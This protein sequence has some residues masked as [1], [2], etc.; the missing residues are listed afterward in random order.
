MRVLLQLIAQFSVTLFLSVLGVSSSTGMDQ[1][2]VKH[3]GQLGTYSEAVYADT[4]LSTGHGLQ[5]H[6]LGAACKS[7]A[8]ASITF[9]RDQP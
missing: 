7:A 9:L 3:D 4:L 8:S 6:T 1:V 5:V 2:Y